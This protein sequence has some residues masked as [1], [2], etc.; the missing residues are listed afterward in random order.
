[1]SRKSKPDLYPVPYDSPES[2]GSE[3]E[4]SRKPVIE[5][6][7]PEKTKTKSIQRP[8]VEKKHVP[9]E[10]SSESEDSAPPKPVKP[11]RVLNE[12]QKE[13]LRLG[14]EKAKQRK[15][16]INDEINRK[17]AEK[18]AEKEARLRE[19]E[20]NEKKKTE[21]MIVKKAI[22]IKK[23]II[24]KKKALEVSSSS[25]DS[26]SEEESVKPTPKPRTRKS[27]PSSGPKQQPITPPPSQPSLPPPVVKQRPAIIFV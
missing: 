15:K 1:M 18:K 17:K 13:N 5:T 2:S 20:E 12:A 22:K 3:S 6:F 8:K 9:V 19:I 7:R 10:S 24:Q 27:E 23:Q 14:R 21:E 4:D 25:E 26:S 16:E 11:K